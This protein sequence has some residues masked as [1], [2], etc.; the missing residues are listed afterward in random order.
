MALERFGFRDDYPI[1]L[2]A[3][4]QPGKIVAVCA[5]QGRVLYGAILEVAARSAS[6]IDGLRWLRV[7]SAAG[8]GLLAVGILCVLVAAGWALEF[9]A[10]AAV[11]VVSLPSAQVLV[12]WVVCGPQ[13]VALLLTLGAFLLAERSPGGPGFVPWLV[14]GLS[15]WVTA[16]AALIY[17]PQSLFSVVFLAGTLAVRRK[18]G[19]RES[20]RYLRR[21]LSALALGLGL[22]FAAIQLSFVTGVFR[23]S[24]RIR[25]ETDWVGKVIWLIT[26]LFPHAL[27]QGVI[28]QRPGVR[29]GLYAVA[30]GVLLA[31]CGIGLALEWLRAGRAGAGRWILGMGLL[32]LAA[33]AVSILAPERLTSYRILYGLAGVWCMFGV[34]SLDN[35][36][37]FLP[38]TAGRWVATG[39]AAL[40]L[41]GA[42]LAGQ[43]S[44]TL[45][46]APQGAELALMEQGAREAARVPS[47][48]FVVVGR[49]DE[50]WTPQRFGDEFGSVSIDADWLA[51]AVLQLLMKER[52]PTDLRVESLYQFRA[53]L[54][55]PDSGGY[56]VLVDLRAKQVARR[57]VPAA[58]PLPVSR[59][60]GGSSVPASRGG[61]LRP[62]QR[63]LQ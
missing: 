38:R 53:G 27:A 37:T 56:D 58:A 51:K 22:A 18:E 31:L 7:A 6:G 42:A 19:F 24:P 41:S 15:A 60:V 39:T 36:S 49:Q 11:L 32:S 23:R 25:F 63:A 52:D 50:G 54:Q 8:L 55:P 35:L 17:P 59:N 34:A 26:D 48:V 12:S 20:V 2:E 44:F 10:S 14:W 28:D 57:G 21:H 5:A 13:V 3:Q 30:I 61:M 29:P 1:L 4:Q 33:C 46:A 62:A 43:Q 45:F 40:A 16:A 9:A 47:Q